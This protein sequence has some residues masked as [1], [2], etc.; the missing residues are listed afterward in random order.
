MLFDVRKS[1]KIPLFTF[2][3][4]ILLTAN[5]LCFAIEYSPGVITG[6]ITDKN[7]NKPLIGA[8]VSAYDSDGA[9]KDEF[10]GKTQT[11]A[12]GQYVI[13]I[14]K[15]SAS[16]QWD[17]PKTS[18]HTQWRPDIY[19]LVDKPQYKRNKSRVY[20]DHMLKN[21]LVINLAMEALPGGRTV[22]GRIYQADGRTPL[23]G[24]LVT[25][26]DADTGTD[27][28]MGSATTDAFG[29]Y[30]IEYAAGSWD[31]P[32]TDHHTQ[33]RPDVFV[34][35]TK[36][37]WERTKSGTFADQ[38]LAVP[39]SINVRVT[40][41]PGKKHTI[42]SNMCEP[43]P[44]ARCKAKGS[45][46]IWLG[47]ENALGR[48]T[49]LRSEVMAIKT[50]TQIG[51][52]HVWAYLAFFETVGSGAYK[53]SLPSYV[54]ST[55]NGYFPNQLMNEVN[56]AASKHTWS[57]NA[58]TD[59]STIYFPADSGRGIV[60]TIENGNIFKPGY[61]NWLKWFLHEL[62]HTK[63]CADWGGRLNY[64]DQW[65]SQLDN[66]VLA[67]IMENAGLPILRMKEIHD[68]MPMERQADSKAD[69]IQSKLKLTPPT[70]SV[71]QPV[72]RVPLTIPESRLPASRRIQ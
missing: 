34:V 30:S 10:I 68:R 62:E 42:T 41:K 21:N 8:E 23:A 5:T 58:M 53:K 56:Y 50:A 40:S 69:E 44:A 1:N 52:P 48:C 71:R 20:T 49:K 4:F 51:K 60:S 17:G 3:L 72:N 33:W 16:S 15:R 39:L 32:K 26:C 19:I 11:D 9:S 13:R 22:R 54:K 63:Q 46:Y 57:G 18:Y 66:P 12:N 28:V 47:P 36:D 43:S 65:F 61:E 27:Q 6:K 45:D 67:E 7:N 25:A 70:P 55:L 35:V 64:A 59:C 37:G 24:A 2:I 14:P 29:N 38:E 31:G